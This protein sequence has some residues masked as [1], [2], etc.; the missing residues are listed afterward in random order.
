M[1][2]N[3]FSEQNNTFV[4]LNNITKQFIRENQMK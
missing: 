1:V 3:Y 4:T 2:L